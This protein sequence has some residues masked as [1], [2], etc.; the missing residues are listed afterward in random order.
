MSRS[1][2]VARKY[3]RWARLDAEALRNSTSSASRFDE[4]ARRTLV[5]R[6]A[7]VGGLVLLPAAGCSGGDE[8][9]FS[10]ASTTTDSS[11]TAPA[12]TEPATTEPTTA[13]P[14]TTEPATTEQTTT[15]PTTTEPTTTEP[16]TTTG[17]S[18]GD[19]AAQ[20]SFPSGGEVIVNFTFTAG[21]SNRGPARN[22][23][24]AVWVEDK[25]GN[26]VSVISAW[27]L[28]EQKGQ[29][30][31]NELRRWYAIGGQEHSANVT[32]STR[33]SG[34]YSVTWD[35][36]DLDGNPVAAGEYVLLIEA[37][38][39]HGPYELVTGPLEISESGYTADLTPQGELTA[40]SVELKV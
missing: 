30:W 15:D 18:S 23:Y 3:A 36:K 37:A 31:L 7:V 34:D 39:E 14:T 12:T 9:A 26:L 40:A 25:E 1:K 33:S 27:Y 5:R 11:T 10:S 32:G 8:K 24:T 35:G 21:S 29:R 16:T 28:Q 20:G 22:P 17:E 6:A 38:R 19:S 2:K 13:E 4:A